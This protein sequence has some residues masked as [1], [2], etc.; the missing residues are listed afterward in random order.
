[1]NKRDDTRREVLLDVRDE[2]IMS[3]DALVE[4]CHRALSAQLWMT[5]C[6]C[7]S[8]SNWK[9]GD[10]NYLVVSVEPDDDTS[11]YVQFWSEPRER[12]CAEIGS[13]ESCPG[14][15]RYIGS[16]QRNA[17]EARGYACGGRAENF[18]REFVIDSAATAEDA[19]REVLQI[20]FEVFGYRGQ[21]QLKIERHRGE[22]AD[23]RPIYMNVTPDDFAKV[24]T[25]VGFDATVT[26]TGDTPLVAVTHG[27]REFQAVM[28][29]RAAKQNLYSLVALQADLT[30]TQPVSDEAISR[31]NSRFRLMKVWRTDARTVRLRMPLSLEGGVTEAWLTQSLHHWISSWRECERQ[32]RR[33]AVPAKPRRISPR[34]VELIH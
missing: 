16:A 24:A 17:I 30:L 14:A 29:W 33:T 22:R 10:Y 25:R 15:I 6:W 32:L 13:G 8:G 21:W 11:L 31:V 7:K 28:E 20:F 19:A 5:C 26:N 23:H 12:V 4:Q 9:I 3:I 18:Q 2:P 1:M 34:R 27:R